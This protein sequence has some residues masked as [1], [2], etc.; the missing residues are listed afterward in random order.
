M[1]YSRQCVEFLNSIEFGDLNYLMFYYLFGE[2]I[3]FFFKLII[4]NQLGNLDLRFVVNV[5]VI[6]V[7]VER[8]I[9]VLY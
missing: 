5:I 7:K 3:I 1:D 8:K 6:F 4:Y 2:L 9:K